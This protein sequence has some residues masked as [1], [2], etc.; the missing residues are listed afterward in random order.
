MTQ[1]DTTPSTLPT[2]AEAEPTP[3]HEPFA[4][5][6]ERASRFSAL[7]DSAHLATPIAVIGC[8][9]VGSHLAL[10][11]AQTGFTNLHL[12]DSDTFGPH[13]LGVQRFPYAH[14]SYNKTVSLYKQCRELN[15]LC[16]IHTYN[17]FHPT[18]DATAYAELGVNNIEHVFMCADSM[19][20]RH[21]AFNYF[22]T[23]PRRLR[24]FTDSRVSVNS[25]TLHQ[26][27]GRMA[28]STYLS[29]VFPDDEA[30]PAPCGARM[31]PH[32]ATLASSYM[33]SLF[34]QF[35]QGTPRSA[36]TYIINPDIPGLT[37]T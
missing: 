25:I 35:L 30:H 23:E 34:F 21:L 6:L 26:W 7:F 28:P 15:P 4:A 27:H 16:D 2:S 33:F 14:L 36:H 20:A 13:N 22:R 29:T 19:E 31:T 11:L 17:H 9:S 5:N 37:S 12:F 8:G 18:F 10:L 24:F 1:T 3:V 32:A